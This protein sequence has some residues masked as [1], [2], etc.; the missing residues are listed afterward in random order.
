MNP[1]GFLQG[2]INLGQNL[3]LKVA[4]IFVN[5][6]RNN[7][8]IASKASTV[9]QVLSPANSV[10]RSP[11]VSGINQTVSNVFQTATKLLNPL[12]AAQAVGYSSGYAQKSTGSVAKSTGNNLQG[13]EDTFTRVGNSIINIAGTARNAAEALGIKLTKS[14]QDAGTSQ[15]VISNVA[16][17]PND[18]LGLLYSPRNTEPTSGFVPSSTGYSDF[19]PSPVMA[20]PSIGSNLPSVSPTLMLLLVAVVFGFFILKKA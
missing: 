16:M 17:I 9:K 11:Q 19:T 12:S 15:P 4:G 5:P 13:I 20:A 6:E 10:S 2:A 1:F 7:P 8:A 14:V 18:L 3:G